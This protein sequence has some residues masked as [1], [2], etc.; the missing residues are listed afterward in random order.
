MIPKKKEEEVRED[1]RSFGTEIA[2]EVA[3]VM[4]WDERIGVVMRGMVC[5]RGQ[6]GRQE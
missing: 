4:R 2:C 5:R 3:D 6:E 1:G